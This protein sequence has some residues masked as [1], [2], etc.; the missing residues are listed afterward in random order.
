MNTRVIRKVPS[1]CTE[2][3]LERKTE[4]YRDPRPHLLSSEAAVTLQNQ[5]I[6]NIKY[7]Y[8]YIQNCSNKYKNRSVVESA[9]GCKTRAMERSRHGL[10]CVVI[11]V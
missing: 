6:K 11:A 2:S 5:E 8:I 9:L 3:P 7:I 10:F 4:R 1:N